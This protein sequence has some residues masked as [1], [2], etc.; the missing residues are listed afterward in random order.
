MGLG[1]IE[2]GGRERGSANTARRF[3]LRR[4][5]ACALAAAGTVVVPGD[6]IH[7]GVG[8]LG[9]EPVS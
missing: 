7:A 6:P 1:R 9:G 4:I 2:N 3:V 5:L 8:T